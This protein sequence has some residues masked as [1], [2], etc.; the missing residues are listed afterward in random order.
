[1]NRLFYFFSLMVVT[2]TLG[3][4]SDDVVNPNGPANSI[5]ILQQE[6]DLFNQ[7]QS[8]MTY[9]DVVNLFNTDGDL[10]RVDDPGQPFET[11]YYRWDLCANDT[12]FMECWFDN[13][14]I[15]L[16][17]K[18]FQSNTCYG[19]IN[20]STFLGLAVGQTYAETCTAIGGD[21]DLYR[22][23]YYDVGPDVEYYRW[24]DCSNRSNYIEA[25]FEDG[26][27]ILIIKT[28]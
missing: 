7:I 5:C 1:M 21:G 20:Q 15:G 25:W 26:I 11:R 14:V 23:D 17:W 10:Y 9:T 4:N 6:S 19:S 18:T 13:D 3:C 27:S 2:F 16:K 28:F 22:V 8:G 24:Y 12:Y